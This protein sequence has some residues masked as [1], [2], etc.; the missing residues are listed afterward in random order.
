MDNL[1]ALDLGPAAELS[2]DKKSQQSINR[3]IKRLNVA[4]SHTNSERSISS[5]TIESI[6]SAIE[7]QI[8]GDFSKTSVLARS[9]LTDS[10][11]SAA[12]DSRVAGVTRSEFS[13]LPL[14]PTQLDQTV[15]SAI[16]SVWFSVFDELTLSRFIKQYHLIGVALAF[17][18]WTHRDR[19]SDIILPRITLLDTEFLS[20]DTLTSQLKYTTTDGSLTVNPGD[21]NWIMMSKWDIGEVVGAVSHLGTD[22]IHKQLA[23]ADWSSGN[24]THQSPMVA[25]SESGTGIVA[26]S[27]EEDIDSLISELQVAAREKFIYLPA[28]KSISTINTDSQYKPEAFRELI[29]F[30]DRKYTVSILGGNLS[31]EV[32]STGANRAAAEVHN[33]VKKQLVQSDVEV[34]SSVI[35]DQL[36]RNIVEA[37]FGSAMNIPWP[38]WSTS[39]REDPAQLISALTTI[40]QLTASTHRIKNIVEIASH[41]GIELEQ[42]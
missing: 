10:A 26:S 31:S 5:W 32:A 33:G 11:F 39:S 19:E 20:Y 41:L 40:S 9:M 27:D 18:D 17:A 4:L 42:L 12:L 15:A 22:W 13:L 35:R 8:R 7:A 2:R 3:K 24:E 29:E 21:G 37:N 34:L 16:E 28:G 6:R 23:V 14:E 25:V 1:A 30:V 38:D 36:V